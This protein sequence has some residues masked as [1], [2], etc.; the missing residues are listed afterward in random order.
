[1]NVTLARIALVKR[2]DRSGADRQ[3]DYLARLE[4]DPICSAEKLPI[5]VWYRERQEGRA[6]GNAPFSFPVWERI[7]SKRIEHRTKIVAV[8]VREVVVDDIACET[9]G[10]VF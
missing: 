1:M 10:V 4:L 7:Y 9:Q 2:R 6:S 3:N 5:V 8:N